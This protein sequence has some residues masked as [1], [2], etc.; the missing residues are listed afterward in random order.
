MGTGKEWKRIRADRGEKREEGQA[1]HYFGYTLVT[2]RWTPLRAPR[3]EWR[4]LS[5]ASRS[6]GVDMSHA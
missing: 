2:I 3:S 1:R 6:C 4:T 5:S